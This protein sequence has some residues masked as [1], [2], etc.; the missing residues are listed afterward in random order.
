MKVLVTGATGFVGSALTRH[1]LKQGY[2]VRIL[3]RRKKFQYILKGLDVEIFDGD[4]THPEA[5]DRA[6]EGCDVVF[7]VASVYQFYPFWEK[8]AKSLYKVNVQGTVNLL[9]ASLKHGIKRFIHTSSIAAIGKRKDGKPS[10]ETTPFNFKGASHYARSKYLAEQEVLK[11]CQKGLECVIL[12]PGIVIGAR[13]YKPTPSGEVLVKFLNQSYPGYFETL[14]AVA[15]VDDVARAHITAITRGRSGERY[16]LC[17]QEHYTL[18][19][20]FQIAEKISGIKAPRLKIPF[21]VLLA[22]VYIDEFLSHTVLH[23]KPLLPTEGVHFCKMSMRFDT[24]KAV[25]ELG[26]EAAPIEETLRKAIS[27]YRK[28]AYIGPRGYFRVKAGGSRLVRSFM[29][30]IG[31]HTL[32]DKLTFGTLSYFLIGQGLGLLETIGVKAKEDGWRKVTRC[33]LR[34]EE[35]KFGL[36]AMGLD[37]WSNA[38]PD[39]SVKDVPGSS[40]ASAAAKT[41]L[42]KRLQTFLK[43]SPET[44]YEITWNIF[45]SDYRKKESV[46]LVEAEFDSSGQLIRIQ[47]HFDGVSSELLEVIKAAYNQTRDLPDKKRPLI[48]KKQLSKLKSGANRSLVN[49]ILSAAFIVFEQAP[50][51]ECPDFVRYKHPGF[52]LLNIVCRFSEDLEY[53]DLWFQFQHSPIDGVPAQEMLDRLILQWGRKKELRFPSI[54]NRPKPEAKLCSTKDGQKGAYYISQFFDFRPFLKFRKALNNRFASKPRRTITA[55]ALLMWKL[56]EFR[57]FEDIKFVLPVDLMTTET[58]RRTLGFVFIRPSAY[59]D[60]N[61]PDRGFFKFQHEFNQQLLATRRRESVGWRLLNRLALAPPFMY[62][63]TASVL[64]DGMHESVG[65]VGLTIIKKSEIFMAP[66]SDVHS[67]GFIALSKFT[68]PTEDG[69]K[70]CVV[71]IKGPKEKIERYIS[72]LDE[73]FHRGIAEDELYF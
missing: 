54:E 24:A 41:H 44:H 9:N 8:Q 1:L 21:P 39:T 20:I 60:K 36:T 33:Y 40:R 2:E 43:E 71:S 30:A 14:W 37:F 27:W 17:N 19:E 58:S 70:A 62:A 47:P 13:D 23:K 7:D 57:E 64:K 50:R 51:F 35:S 10:D 12:N 31:M 11:F 3:V 56:A 69:G 38:K 6:V 34:T 4:V 52:G 55:G 63:L 61:R 25:R 45:S 18:K 48:L 26:Y 5:V 42:I 67:N 29:R 46:D 73:V 53:A 59:F 32:T 28:N 15:D 49:R 65:S 72:I 68:T 66:Y 16:V 22:V